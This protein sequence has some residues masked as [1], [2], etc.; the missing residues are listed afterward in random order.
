MARAWPVHLGRLDK[1]REV[2]TR[3]DKGRLKHKLIQRL[4]PD[5]GVPPLREHLAS[6]T[7]IMK[8]ADDPAKA[9]AACLERGPPASSGFGTPNPG[10]HDIVARFTATSPPGFDRQGPTSTVSSQPVAGK[11]D[12][13]TRPRLSP[14]RDS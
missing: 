3:D 7:T 8:L 6:V 12:T 5:A 14:G 9:R 2:T 4:M 11:S 1:L 13:R 10:F